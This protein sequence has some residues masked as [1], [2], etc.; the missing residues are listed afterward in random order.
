MHFL[1]LL[2]DFAT[3]NSWIE[4]G[5]YLVLFL[6][7]FSMG[8]GLPVPEDIPLIISGALIAHGKFHWVP[9]GIAAWCGI[10]GGDMVLYH[11][12]KKF[13]LEITRVP[14]IGKHVTKKRIER[15]EHLFERYGVWV[16][17]VGRLIAGIRGAMVVAAGASKFRFITF[18]I[19]D[20]LAA[21]VSGGLFMLLGFW[22][23]QNMSALLHD[24]ETVKRY[25]LWGAIIA[26]IVFGAYWLWRQKKHTTLSDVALTKVEKVVEARRPGTEKATAETPVYTPEEKTDKVSGCPAGTQ[27][28]QP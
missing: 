27:D 26:A 6:L 5:G 28:R 17:A 15:V 8:L 9:A 16:V 2:P 22:L 10:I 21:L 11:L 18:V 13:G 14:F 1:A 20:G 25:L 24:V 23:G 12:G 3:L 19:A 4:A 7:L